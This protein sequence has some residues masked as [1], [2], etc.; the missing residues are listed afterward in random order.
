[1]QPGTEHFTDEQRDQLAAAEALFA[2]PQV[3]ADPADVQTWLSSSVTVIQ[4]IDV[5]ELY[6]REAG[7]IPGSQ[8]IEIERLGWNAPTIDR[9]LPVVF[10]CRLGIRAK[11]AA[12]AFQRAGFDAKSLTGGFAAWHADGRPVWPDDATVADH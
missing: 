2:D 10:Y 6:E 5:R 12:Y 3:E 7:H 8:H 4:V 9:K 1:M 11:L